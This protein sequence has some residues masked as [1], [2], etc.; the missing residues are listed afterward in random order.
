[1]DVA[2]AGV[3]RLGNHQVDEAHDRRVLDLLAQLGQVDILVAVGRGRQVDLVED[4]AEMLGGPDLRVELVDRLPHVGGPRDPRAQGEPRER[5]EMIER[6]HVERVTDRDLQRLAVALQG[7]HVRLPREVLG[8]QLHRLGGGFGELLGGG[9]RQVELFAQHLDDLGLAHEPQA[10]H[11]LPEPLPRV[12]A[13]AQRGLHLL[14]GQP[15]PL[16]QDLAETA[17]GEA[18]AERHRRPSLTAA[19]R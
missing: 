11:G 8:D 13:G 4:L 9:D 5:P 7:Q 3:D 2:G 17:R 15:A 16:D 6:D 12:L 19:V 1:M 18:V 14:R 10:D